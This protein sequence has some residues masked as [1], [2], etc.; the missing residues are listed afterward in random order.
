[1]LRK[2][3]RQ[4][5]VELGWSG[6]AHLPLGVGTHEVGSYTR[7]LGV[8]DAIARDRIESDTTLVA[9]G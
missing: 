8:R 3:L 9:D 4:R 5:E 6:K 1:L 2:V 7:Y